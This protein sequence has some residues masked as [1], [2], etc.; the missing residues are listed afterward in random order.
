M[1]RAMA[2]KKEAAGLADEVVAPSSA[3]PL[4]AALWVNGQ[5]TAVTILDQRRPELH[6][7][8]CAC[9][10]CVAKLLSDLPIRFY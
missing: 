4:P 3:A 5:F 6:A 9:S 10:A 1:M 7:G 8:E 2:L